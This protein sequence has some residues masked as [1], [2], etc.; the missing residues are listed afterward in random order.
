MDEYSILVDKFIS[1]YKKIFPKHLG[2]DADRMCHGM[3][4]GMYKVI[5]EF[6]QSTGVVELPTLGS[7]CDLLLQFK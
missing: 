7:Y 3:F 5:V 4:K 1:G 6:A 2:D